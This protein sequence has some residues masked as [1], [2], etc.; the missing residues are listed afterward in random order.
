VGAQH[1]GAHAKNLCLSSQR[2]GICPVQMCSNLPAYMAAQLDFACSWDL[3]DAFKFMLAKVTKSTARVLPPC[4][5]ENTVMAHTAT[6]EG[7]VLLGG[8]YSKCALGQ[9]T[10]VG[11]NARI[12]KSVIYGLKDLQ[13]K[14][15]YADE[16][17]VQGHARGIGANVVLHNVIVCGD[18]CIGDNVTIVN[19]HRLQSA[20]LSAAGIVVQDGVVVILDQAVIPDGFSL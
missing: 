8:F 4:Y 7:T 15:G 2:V 18:V 14:A 12:S 16:R 6:T 17:A 19:R 1:A 10:Y 11:P 3:P 20:D 9:C 13:N 5:C